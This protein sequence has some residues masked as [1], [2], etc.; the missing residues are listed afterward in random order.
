MNRP[1]FIL[2]SFLLVGLS[3]PAAAAVN[4]WLDHDQV[5]PGETVQL[6]LQ[7]D[8]QTD[9]EPDLA[10][11]QQDFDIAGRSSGSNIRIINGQMNAQTQIS[12]MLVPKHNGKLQIPALHWDGDRKSVV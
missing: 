8:G 2:M 7:H 3:L 1:T 10:P 5:G 4:A 11:L 6:T 9:A 12:L